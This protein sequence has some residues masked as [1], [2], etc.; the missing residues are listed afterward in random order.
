MKQI[1][2]LLFIIF[3]SILAG[4][5]PSRA[6]IPTLFEYTGYYFI[7]ISFLLW[8][9]YL[10]KIYFAKLKSIIRN[11]YPGLLLSVIL[12]TLIFC[13]AP[14]KFKV[15]ADETNLIG[16]SMA[17]FQS[18]KASL[19]LQGFN[20][21][22][23]KPE[24]SSKVDKR[25]I[26]YPLLI[27]LVHTLRGYSAYNG[28]VV[29]FIC[30]ILVLFVFY[31]F[32]YGH[33]PRI[34]ALISI[35]IVASLPNFV[36]WVTSSGFE[37]LN[38]FFI[39]FTLFL[40]NKTLCTRRIKH[41][42]LLWLTLVLVSQCRYE[43][44][45]FTV[46]I[47]FLLPFFCNKKSIAS[48]SL[49]S[50]SVPILF[51]PSLWL[52]RLHADRPII[53]KMAMGTVSAASLFDAF[54]LSNL[55][56]NT[57][58]NMVV[59]LG[60]DPH[61]GFSPVISGMSAAGIYLMTK[62]MI[63][64]RRGTSL[65][66]RIMWFCGFLT[67]GLLYAVQVSFYLGDMSLYTQNRFA[68]TYLPVIVFPV[69][70]FVHH[71]ISHTNNQI[72]V[73]VFVL[74]AF[75]LFYFWPYGSQQRIVQTG[76]I[77]YEYNKTLG[78]LKDNFKHDSNILIICERPYYYIVHYKSAVNF[79]YANQNTEKIRDYLEKEFDHIVVLQKCLYE[80]RAPVENNQLNKSYRLVNLKN[81]KLTQTEFLKISEL[82]QNY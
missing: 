2:V 34:Y 54:S 35:L 23:Q 11:H 78:Y 18:K 64:E 69:V 47:L 10:F 15:L 51:I 3:V 55:L 45:I 28:F 52:F 81:L 49:F 57:A 80:N 6:R 74:F 77:P 30:G 12:M 79:N 4:I 66:F 7:F 59:F 53:D 5:L 76:S 72:K 27:S 56:S 26:F 65:Q 75:H 25:P 41:A 32:I 70:Y 37:T 61:L 67:F 48:L 39:V 68:M 62:K 46:A 19:P 60:L 36:I 38:L 22:Y 17:M 31:L 73:A 42:E 63:V 8:V 16:I 82:I 40:F 50:Y 24:Y 71:F 20:I 9:V 1:I 14:P 44:I 33:F 58:T 43:S 29:N 21:D 13:I